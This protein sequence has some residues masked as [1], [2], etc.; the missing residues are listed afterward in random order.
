MK[1]NEPC[2]GVVHQDCLK[3]SDRI[4]GYIEFPA[5]ENRD[6]LKYFDIEKWIYSYSRSINI[7]EKT[8]E[9][10]NPSIQILWDDTYNNR[11]GE[12]CIGLNLSDGSVDYINKRAKIESF[13]SR[14]KEK[15]L[16]FAK[17]MIKNGK[18]LKDPWCYLSESRQFGKYSYLLTQLKDNEEILEIKDCF[19]DDYSLIVKHSYEKAEYYYAPLLFLVDIKS[20]EDFNLGQFSILLSNP[21]EMNK[22]INNW[23]IG[24]ETIPEY[25][26]EILEN[27]EKVDSFFRDK[28]DKG[29]EI[30]IDPLID[31]NHNIMTA[32]PI[33]KMSAILK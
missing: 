28:M 1:G 23:K 12:Y 5:F 26:V 6:W 17:D 14:K 13:S 32:I 16:N 31:K 11:E 20:G 22:Y 25:R 21:F 33:M 8:R 27:D 7:V 2:V 19:I 15:E 30:L 9:V 10:K 3:G 24:G 29:Y 18:D 4:L